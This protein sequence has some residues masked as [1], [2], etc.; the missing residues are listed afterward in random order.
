MKER[1]IKLEKLKGILETL[2][3]EY[4]LFEDV[5]EK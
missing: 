5:E 4:A 2:G 1:V 3:L